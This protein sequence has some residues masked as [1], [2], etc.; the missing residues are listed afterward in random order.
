MIYVSEKQAEERWDL[1]PQ[2]LREALFSEFVADTAEQ[3]YANHHIDDIKAEKINKICALVLMGFLHPEEVSQEIKE[4]LDLTREVTDPLADDLDKKIFS[5]YSADIKDVYD[6]AV[7]TSGTAAALAD[8]TSAEKVISLEDIGGTQKTG[9]IPVETAPASGV[10][11][12]EQKPDTPFILHDEN[13]PEENAAQKSV[14]RSVTSP[15]GGFFLKK[16]PPEESRSPFAKLE[17]PGLKPKERRI[18]HYSETRTPLSQL[19]EPSFLNVGEAQ[20]LA[21]EPAPIF[22]EAPAERPAV[23]IK[24]KAEEVSDRVFGAP[25]SANTDI[26]VELPAVS[27]TPEIPAGPAILGAIKK[28]EPKVEGNTIDLKGE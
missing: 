17:I 7:R 26:G 11:L 25:G 20:P 3:V 6:P 14:F 4:E 2:V 28:P 13:A 1:L 15:L 12:K 24:P 10:T 8:K 19:E 9:V 16:R 5:Q 22:T 23:I 18:V 21:A 27:S